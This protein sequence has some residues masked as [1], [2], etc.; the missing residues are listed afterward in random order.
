MFLSIRHYKLWIT[1][2]ILGR[3]VYYFF[4]IIGIEFAQEDT[5][6]GIV[7]DRKYAVKEIMNDA[8]ERKKVSYAYESA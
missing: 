8:K 5:T 3:I 1:F 4:I 7:S 2:F 6:V